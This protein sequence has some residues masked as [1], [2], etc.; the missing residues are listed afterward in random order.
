MMYLRN[1]YFTLSCSKNS[2]FS[3]V[4]LSVSLFSQIDKLVS[5]VLQKLFFCYDKK[6]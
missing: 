6:I 4:V 5:C 3:K 1:T 2:D